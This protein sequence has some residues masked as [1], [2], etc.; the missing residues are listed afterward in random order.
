MPNKVHI[1]EINVLVYL[2]RVAMSKVPAITMLWMIMLS[3]LPK[4]P[5]T[6][7]SRLWFACKKLSTGM[8]RIGVME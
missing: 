7:E 3:L 5:T 4:V 2:Q 8:F 1:W 6:I